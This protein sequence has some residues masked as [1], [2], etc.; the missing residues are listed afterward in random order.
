LKIQ[1]INSYLVLFNEDRLLLLRR[2][3]GFWEFP[4]GGVDWGE[5][6]QQAAVRE[7]KEETGLSAEN[8]KF[9]TVTSATYKKGEDEKHSVYLVYRG[10]TKG[11]DVVLSGEHKESRWLT[12]MEAKFMKLA[13]NAEAVLQHL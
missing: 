4:G 9:V 12:P 5:E 8:I 11:S 7:T 6:P 13:L 1:E 2:E 3:S 10:E